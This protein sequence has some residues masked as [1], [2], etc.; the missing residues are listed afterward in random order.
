M[1]LAVARLDSEAAYPWRCEQCERHG[2]AEH[3]I[4]DDLDA[5]RDSDGAYLA[6]DRIAPTGPARVASMKLRS[7]PEAAFERVGE[8]LQ[9]WRIGDGELHRVTSVI[10]GTPSA[11]FVDAWDLLRLEMGALRSALDE[12][13]RKRG[14]KGPH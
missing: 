3:G 12:R 6:G 14:G 11:A 13:A 1:S 7:C 5:E 10:G 4:D 8:L 9:L 2:V